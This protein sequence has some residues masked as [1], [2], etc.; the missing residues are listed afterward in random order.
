MR[1][2]TDSEMKL[3]SMSQGF[4][5]AWPD[6][7]RVVP[8][9]RGTGT[10]PRPAMRA[11]ARYRYLLHALAPSMIRACFRPTM[12]SRSNRKTRESTAGGCLIPTEL[13]YAST[14]YW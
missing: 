13:F 1:A 12:M 11:G 5:L 8:C 7:G 10:S 9:G 2:A 3:R 4:P 6:A 14:V